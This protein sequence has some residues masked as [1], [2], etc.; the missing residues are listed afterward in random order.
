M[1]SGDSCL[2]CSLIL[3]KTT[4]LELLPTRKTGCSLVNV[5]CD[6]RSLLAETGLDVIT[7]SVTSCSLAGSAEMDLHD[8]QTSPSPQPAT[9]ET[10]SHAE[11]CPQTAETGLH[12][13]QTLS[14]S[15]VRFR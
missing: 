5:S 2:V 14:V 7:T 15:A 13:V 11:R 3:S 9:L 10:K 8:V 6:H 12:V 1:V 4:R